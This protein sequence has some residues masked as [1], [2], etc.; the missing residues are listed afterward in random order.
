MKYIIESPLTTTIGKLE[1][2]TKIK[3]C[4]H[5]GCD[6][7]LRFGDGTVFHRERINKNIDKIVIDL[8]PEQ[9]Q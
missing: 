1:K 8:G 4:Q 2:E 3:G 9:G 5:I 6:I 7:I